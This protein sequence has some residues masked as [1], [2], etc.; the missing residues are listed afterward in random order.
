MTRMWSSV[1]LALSIQVCLL[2]RCF[3]SPVSSDQEPPAGVVVWGEISTGYSAMSN[4]IIELIP[5]NG[6]APQRIAPEFDGSFEFRD[7]TPGLHE[8]RVSDARGRLLYDEV[9]SI[10]GNERLSI[11]P[12]LDEP[13]Q[14]SKA[15]MVSVA[16]LRHK[17]PREAHVEFRKGTEALKKREVRSAVDHLKAAVAIDPAFADAHNDLAVA[18]L[19][20]N[21][22]QESAEHFQKAIELD[23]GYQPAG[24]NLCVVLLKMKRYAEAGEVAGRILKTGAGS[25]VAHYAAAVSLIAAGGNRNEAL[26]HLRR[27]QDDI[28]KGRVLAASILAEAGR[29]EDAAAEL[30]A[31]LRSP[32]QTVDRSALEAWLAELRK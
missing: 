26:D 11:K 2:P 12:R 5:R 17:I 8:V 10:R 29:R 3:A 25:A 23:P 28:P 21:E 19:R 6:G 24:N 9:I 15:E 14:S 32:D 30:E 16:Q 27:A 31:Y 20:L 4:W 13:P 1:I 7:V 18:Y 22:D